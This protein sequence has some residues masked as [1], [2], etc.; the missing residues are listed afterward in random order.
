MKEQ[1]KWA[2]QK[3][4]DYSQHIMPLKHSVE[5][6]APKFSGEHPFLREACAQLGSPDESVLLREYGAGDKIEESHRSSNAPV[7]VL[8]LAESRTYRFAYNSGQMADTVIIRTAEG[9]KP[10]LIMDINTAGAHSHFIECHLAPDSALNLVTVQR[11]RGGI[12]M[13]KHFAEL[14]ERASLRIMHLDIGAD[15]S[16][17]EQKVILAGRGAE[18]ANYTSAFKSGKQKCD[19]N[20]ESIHDAEESSSEIDCAVML[21]DSSLM[22]ARTLVQINREASRSKGLEKV[23]A[24]LMSDKCSISA[25]P[26]LLIH[27]NDVVCTHSVAIS[28]LDSEKKFYIMS[29]GIDESGATAMLKEAFIKNQLEKIAV[30]EVKEVEM[31]LHA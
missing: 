6:P 24:L 13:G 15:L 4:K 21:E 25:V 20:I 22:N 31:M 26:D 14:A 3:R 23:D 16:L 1:H 18:A 2:V 28:S 27:N 9:K 17:V 8:D 7:V 10:T 11:M 19:F 30:E 29:R 12:Y 5:L